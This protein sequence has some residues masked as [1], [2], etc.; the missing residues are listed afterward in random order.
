MVSLC[1]EPLAGYRNSVSV[2]V[3]TTSGQFLTCFSFKIAY[4]HAQN[5][6]YFKHTWLESAQ[7]YKF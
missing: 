1:F 6:F 3:D 5:A 2:I 7:S 4:T